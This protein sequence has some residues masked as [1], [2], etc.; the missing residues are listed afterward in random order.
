M[1]LQKENTP[2]LAQ[3]YIP[4]NALNI[5]VTLRTKEGLHL[6]FHEANLTN[7]P[8]MPLR[9]DKKAMR[10]ESE[11]V[12][13]DRLDFKAKLALPFETP[14]RTIHI[15]EKASDLIASNLIAN[16][17]EPNNLGDI[18]WFTLKKIYRYLAGNTLKNIGLGVG[19][20]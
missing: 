11:L 16:L 13:S 2:N 19:K 18:S 6:S 9:V 1:L 3:T 17:N 20:R 5:P 4:S 7:Y 12:G 14:W 15:T 8:G 10:F